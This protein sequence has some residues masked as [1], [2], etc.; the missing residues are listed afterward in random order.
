[1]CGPPIS[2]VLSWRRCGYGHDCFIFGQK[3]GSGDNFLAKWGFTRPR[4]CAVD[5]SGHIFVADNPTS[6]VWRVR[7]S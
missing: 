7:P 3:L 6:L 1:M 2:R 5:D 4:F